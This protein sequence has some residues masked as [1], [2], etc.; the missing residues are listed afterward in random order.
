MSER[1]SILQESLAAIERLQARLEASE[2][3]L[4]QPIA[5]VGA[6]CRY[7]GGI[8]SPEA[9]WRVVRDGVDAVSE[10]PAD[11]WDANAYYDPDPQAAGKMVTRRGGFL[12]QVDRFDPQFF[13]IS[14]REAAT[15]DPQQ[16]LLLETASEA[17]E[18][19]GLASDRLAGSLTGVFVGITTSDYGQLLRNGGAENSDVYSA[20]GSALNAAAGRLSFTYGFQGPCVAVDTACSSSLVAVHLACQS[21]RTGESNLALAGGVNVVL[22]P[23]AMVLFSRWGMMAPDGACKTFDAAADGFVRAEGCAVIALKRLSDAVAAGDPIL[24][25]IRGS[26]VNSDGRSSGLTVPNGPAQQAVLRAALA[27]AGLEPAAIDYVEAHGTGTSLGDPIEVEALGEVMRVG[28]GVD[29]P[30]AIGSI[31]TNLGHTEAAS[32]LA[33][34]LKV[35]MSLRHEAI[36][37]HLH[38]NTP[39]PGIPWADLPITVPT[40]LTLWPRGAAKRRA[41]VSSFGFSGTNA[42]VILEEAPLAAARNGV[43]VAGPYIVPLSARDEAALRA[44]AGNIEEVLS[45]AGAPPVPAAVVDHAASPTVLAAVHHAVAAPSPAPPSLA[46][47]VTTLATGRVHHTRRLALITDSP[48]DLR[49]D[50][51][52]IAAGQFNV[53]AA[54]GSI[55]AGQQP[56]IA[57]LFT[58]QGAQYPGMGRGL[59]DTEPVFRAQIDKAASVLAPVLPRPLL[60]VLFPVDSADN[61]LAQTAYTQPALFVLEYALAELWRSWGITPS[62]V[63][64]HS[65]G[66][67]AAACVAGVF[68]LEE[69]LAL[70]A[71]RARLMQALPAGG[72]MAAVFADEKW[73]LGRLDGLSHLSIA[74]INGPEQTVV[75]GD[76]QALARLLENCAAAGVK[77]KT[78]DVSHAFHS[79]LLDPMLDALERRAAAIQHVPPRIPLVSNL[80]GTVFGAGAG[81]DARYWRI[82]AREP[83]RFAASL[84]ALQKTGVTA[85][86]EIGPHP[87]LLAFAARGLPAASWLTASS[88]R[89][90]RDDRREMLTSLASLYAKGAPVQWDAVAGRQGGRRIALPTYPFQRERYWVDPTGAA[91]PVPGHG[92]GA[93]APRASTA[94]R[95]A[96]ENGHP[97]LGESHALASAPGTHVW[98]RDISLDSHPWLGDHRVQGA[99]IVPATAY[100]EMALAAGGEVLGDGSL[101]V[102]EI[103]NLKPI[104][105]HDGVAHRVQVTL[106]EETDG[107]ARFAVHGRR[108]FA[109]A[110]ANS[111]A[112]WIEHMTARLARIEPPAEVDNA[113]GVLETLKSGSEAVLSGEQF[114]ALLANKGNQWGS[115]FQGMR[116]VWRQSGEALGRI[117]VPPSLLGEVGRYRFH[118]AV[119]DSC[120]HALVATVPLEAAAGPRGGAFVG[121]GVGEI[122]FHRSAAG[123]TLWSRAVLRQRAEGDGN[124]VIGDVWVYDETGALVSETLEARLWYLDDG[125]Q[126][127]LLG[128]PPDWFYEV[129]WQQQAL[130]GASSRSPK[131]GPWVVFADRSGLGEK[132]ASIRDAAGL[133][134]VLVTPGDAWHA[135]GT[136]FSL[137]A[138][139]AE[140]YARLLAAVDKPAAVLHL[141]SLD[142]TATTPAAGA[143][144]NTAT[145]DTA[146][147]TATAIAIA[148]AIATANT[149]GD[150]LESALNTGVESVLNLLH[151]IRSAGNSVRPRLWLLTSGAQAVIAGDRT[152]APWA[153]ALWGVGKSLSV[154]HAEIWG[155]L[156][157][158]PVEPASDELAQR[159]IHEVDTA[160]A[161]DQV[162]FRG[163]DRWVARLERRAP[164]MTRQ[165]FKP[166]NNGTYLV[167]G[168][169]GG[170]GLAMARWLVEQGARHLLLLG[171]TALPP[172]EQWTQLDPQSAAARRVAAISALEA[173]GARVD[174]SALDVADGEALRRCLEVRRGAGQPPVRGVIHAAGVLKFEALETQTVQSLREVLAAKVRGAWELHRLLADEPLDC[175]VLCSST[176]ALLRS[177]LLGGYAAGNAFL[178]ALAH[179]RRAAGLPAL[180]VN[181]GTWGEVGMAVEAGRGA[182][183]SMLTGVATISTARGLAAL[184]ELLETQATQAAVMPIDW[185]A[186]VAAYPA[187]AADVFLESQVA[188]IRVRG[189]ATRERALTPASL[190]GLD[191]EARART[192]QTYLHAEAARVLGFVP[193]RLDPTAPLSSFGFDS[194]MAVQLKNRIEADLGL[195]VPMIQFLQGPSVEQLVPLLLDAV[196]S[197]TERVAPHAA[198]EELWEVGSL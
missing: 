89:R 101:A 51:R 61:D 106:I 126:T 195:V 67:Y 84:E 115:A 131:A 20:T 8:E 161:E 81:P 168:G 55:R 158:I 5:I 87:T 39:N 188:G 23:E 134:T 177:P 72:G 135:D 137:R 73:V 16:R 15:L 43:A 99:A 21:L 170:V 42:H 3:A 91:A 133:K 165:D 189:A 4:R 60:E 132:I 94:T 34:L 183:G 171:R 112:P 119:S 27:N 50:L 82:H 57:F 53:A 96:T 63:M 38:F 194:L 103:E 79:H 36:P 155:G 83:V 159:V 185:D 164:G 154:E 37:P 141:W 48:E 176:S 181:W 129:R 90:G 41:G 98:Q 108:V 162:A 121:G 80:T 44:T 12:S 71:E 148:I 2:H 145:A 19:A 174:A 64:G 144:T 100:I 102:R 156:I 109:G 178:D 28:R 29:R 117:D 97:L 69:G 182:S 192:V 40:K 136:R 65:V 114:Y 198:A 14:P 123:N 26:A 10:I 190:D 130:T 78:L 122:R 139:E 153:A 175:F 128:V 143:T 160:T 76:A 45:H 86:L 147:A 30:L 180:S 56:K 95:A 167:T 110:P 35:V 66:E 111:N 173:L 125:A 186:F 77:S 191:P 142:P 52:A 58:G 127:E 59:Y 54:E 105:L 31:K 169:L 140:D 75:A 88:M 120:G 179:Q 196:Q 113:F 62:I 32:G 149:T 9:L 18:S 7:P 152:Q 22:S 151:G 157:D 184:R 1:R 93:Q 11:R 24:A 25:V 138:A 146:T 49:R 118:P 116:Q 33:G 70:I 166:S 172:R 68:T 85:L 150:A 74:A 6:G 13:G 163:R 187:F 197:P 17:L 193:A 47:V 107:S 92:G 104:I 46:D 124:V